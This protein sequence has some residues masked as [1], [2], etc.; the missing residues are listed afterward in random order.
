MT[1]CMVHTCSTHQKDDCLFSLFLDRKRGKV[2]NVRTV[3]GYSQVSLRA[4]KGIR[5]I[6]Q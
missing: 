3:S 2:H 1:V 6:R 5:A 4:N